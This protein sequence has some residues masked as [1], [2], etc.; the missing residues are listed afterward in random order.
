MKKIILSLLILISFSD[1][2]E[3]QQGFQ[4]NLTDA[5]NF[6]FFKPFGVGRNL[7]NSDM[8]LTERGIL[9]D[10]YQSND[11]KI[12]YRYNN[13]HPMTIQ[14]HPWVNKMFV[15]YVDGSQPISYGQEIS[16]WKSALT[17]ENLSGKVSIGEVSTIGD[18]LLYVEKGILAE[19]VRVAIKSTSA[20]ADYVFSE[21]YKLLSIQE[22]KTFIEKNKHLPGVPSAKELVKKG[23]EVAEMD[24]KL[25]EKIE[26]LTLH[27]IRQEEKIN[28]LEDRLKS[29]EQ[30]NS[31]I[32]K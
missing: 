8:T 29:I 12:R 22:T 1:L 17:I 2:I 23:L 5:P 24:A 16:S 4:Q 25:L 6:Y 30:D 14:Y 18:Y 15:S 13:Y 10:A 31:L 28:L 27:I 11:A 9:F 20:W 26:E 21:D 32:K 19:K 3:A 7:G